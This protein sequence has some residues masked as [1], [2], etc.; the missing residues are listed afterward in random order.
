MAQLFSHGF[1]V[2]AQLQVARCVVLDLHE[3]ILSI[4]D[5]L[6]VSYQLVAHLLDANLSTVQFNLDE[7]VDADDFGGRQLRH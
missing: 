3:M 6:I 1:V 7:T 5:R 2:D 4:A